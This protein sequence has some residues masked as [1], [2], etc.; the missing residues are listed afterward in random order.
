MCGRVPNHTPKPLPKPDAASDH[1]KQSLVHCG[2]LTYCV[3]LLW[4]CPKPH[5]LFLMET[6]KSL[7]CLFKCWRDPNHKPLYY[8][9]NPTTIT[10]TDP[11]WTCL[12]SH[13][14]FIIQPIQLLG[15]LYMCGRVPI[16]TAS[17]HSETQPATIPNKKQIYCWSVPNYTFYFNYISYPTTI[18]VNDS[19]W[20]CP[21]LHSLCLI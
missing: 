8:I 19:L 17:T 4:K 6:T 5:T 2:H 20:T 1:T 13:T 11:L 12:K 18:T 14:V 9:S 7:G 10:V 3:F 15:C 16:H 21:K